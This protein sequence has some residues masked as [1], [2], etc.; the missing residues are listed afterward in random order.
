MEWII[1]ACVVSYL[2]GVWTTIFAKK[3]K[4]SATFIID[5]TDAT[6]DVCTLELI[7]NLNDIYSKKEILVKVKTIGDFTQ[8]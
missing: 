5:C 3:T 6:K 7:E 4:P 8:N 2:L 1:I